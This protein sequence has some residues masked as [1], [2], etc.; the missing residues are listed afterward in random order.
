MDKISIILPTYNSSKYIKETINSILNQTYTNFELIIVDDNSK[1]DTYE[2]CLNS[3]KEDSRIKLLKNPQKG[4]SSA[5]NVGINNAIGKYIMFIDSD[6]LYEQT[7]LEKMINNISKND[8]AICAYDKQY[9]NVRKSKKVRCENIKVSVDKIISFLQSNYLFNPVW[10]K[11]YRRDIIENN[12][13]RFNNEVSIAEDLEFNLKYFD[14]IEKIVY[15]DEALYIYKV[16]NSGLNFSYHRDRIVIRKQLYEYQKEIFV[17]KGY[18]I[19]LI[20]SEYI[21]ICLAELRQLDYNF[22]EIIKLTQDEKR[23]KELKYIIKYGRNIQ[24][25]FCYF[26]YNKMLLRI[27]VFFMKFL[28]I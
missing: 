23:M 20:F 9:G 25:I 17:R 8:I 13:I 7:M 3:K 27:V 11:I 21:K 26:M 4:V 28:H 16:S 19:R 24:K 12:N 22:K 14:K 10:N 18:D 2:C 15:I 5:R 6:D 1:D